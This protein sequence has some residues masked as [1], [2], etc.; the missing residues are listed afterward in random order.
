MLAL[1]GPQPDDRFL[2]IGPGN[3]ALTAPLLPRVTRLAA[4]EI[5][6]ALAAG[7]RRRF[8]QLDHFTLI[9]GDALTL[10]M[11]TVAMHLECPAEQPRF[12]VVGNL[13]YS[14]ATAIISRLLPRLDRLADLTVM[15]QQ[16]VAD[17]LT[18][19]PGE[20]AYGALS[21]L[22]HLHAEASAGFGL[23]PGSFSPPPAVHSRVVS[24]RLRP[25][26]GQAQRLAAAAL[27]RHA[28]SHR[29]KRLVNALK[30]AGHRVETIENTLRQMNLPLTARAQELSATEF[31]AL[32]A[33]IESRT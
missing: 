28:F 18:A 7:L 8:D 2:E 22:V 17:R 30:A 3:G 6:P 33:G 24:F 10:D 5:D 1:L 32:S 19:R 9:E 27:A 31:L 25:L 16:E 13:P 15:V 23:G 12:R 11:E 29:R 20:A 21:V 14:V 4:V 26:A